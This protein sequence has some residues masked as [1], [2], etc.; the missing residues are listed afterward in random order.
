MVGRNKESVD[1]LLAK[2]KTHLTQSDIERR[3]TDEVHDPDDNIAAPSYLTKKQREEFD[4]I[5]A[6]GTIHGGSRVE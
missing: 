5:S 6:G 3:R 2:G 1:L 4:E